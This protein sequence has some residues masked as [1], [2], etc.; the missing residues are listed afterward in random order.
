MILSDVQGIEVRV[1][2][3]DPTSSPS[4]NGVLVGHV[5]DVRF[6]IRLEPDGTPGRPRI[7]GLLISPRG[8]ASFLGY[9][10]SDLRRPWP[11]ARFQRWYHRGSF[12]AAW[13]DVVQ[14]GRDGVVLRAGYIPQ[15]VTLDVSRT[16]GQRPE[17]EHGGE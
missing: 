2:D 11:I 5:V 15:S 12:L 6:A 7:S 17:R 13:Q 9:E 10:R 3:S 4:A 14:F 8:R 1:A 16:P